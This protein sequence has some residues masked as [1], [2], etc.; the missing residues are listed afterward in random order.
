MAH[1]FRLKNIADT[2][3]VKPCL[4]SVPEAGAVRRGRNRSQ[5]AR[6]RQQA[7]YLIDLAAAH[8]MRRQLGEALRGLQEAEQ[9]APELTRTHR[10]ARDGTRDLLQ[11]SGLRPRARAARAGRALRR[12][13][14]P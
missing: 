9:I 13:A 6:E 7:R 12:T 10:V 5:L 1:S 8:A 14:V 11:L 3:V 2:E 4:V